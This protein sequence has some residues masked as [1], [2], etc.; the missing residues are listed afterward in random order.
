[1]FAT[2]ATQENLRPGE[3]PRRHLGEIAGQTL[4][5]IGKGRGLPEVG[6]THLPEAEEVADSEFQVPQPS[7]IISASGC[8]GQKRRVDLARCAGG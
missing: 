5:G 2:A 4:V 7:C 3:G 6:E 1:M 8:Y